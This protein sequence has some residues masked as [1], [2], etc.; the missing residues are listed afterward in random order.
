[1]SKIITIKRNEQVPKTLTIDGGIA[2]CA[3]IVVYRNWIGTLSKVKAFPT[4]VGILDSEGNSV[5]YYRFCDELGKK[6]KDSH[7]EQINNYLRNQ[8]MLGEI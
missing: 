3:V 8:R 7:S 6:L 1:M 5:L 2:L 4:P